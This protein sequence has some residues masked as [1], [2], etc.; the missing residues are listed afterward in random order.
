MTKSDL[1][2]RG[3]REFALAGERAGLAA[4]I[5]PEHVAGSHVHYGPRVRVEYPNARRI[6][7][8]AAA[9]ARKLSKKGKP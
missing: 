2:S 8:A 7:L 4:L 6:R 9:K 5:A 1:F 3:S